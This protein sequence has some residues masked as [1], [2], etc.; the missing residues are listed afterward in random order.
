MIDSI[1]QWECVDDVLSDATKP[2]VETL[3]AAAKVACICGGRWSAAAVQCII[4]NKIPLQELCRDVLS[5]LV[6]GRSETTPVLVL[7]GAR[8]G[9]GKSLFLKPLQ[10]V[11]GDEC[12]FK[13]GLST[14]ST[15]AV[16][17]HDPRQTLRP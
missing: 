6:H 13:S 11:F 8:G 5:A 17:P 15:T 7:A 2:R 10:R 14:V 12:V 9:D 1:W 16:L 4:A 3:R